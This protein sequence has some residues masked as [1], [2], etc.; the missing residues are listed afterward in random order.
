MM[1]PWFG[2]YNGYG[3]FGGIIMMLLG[4]APIVLIVYLLLRGQNRNGGFINQSSE[5]LEI[6]K[7]RLARG[8]ISKDE[9]DAIKKN[10]K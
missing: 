1:G 8:E 10:L 5:A 2:Y 3:L 4:I 6:A 9:F 7:T